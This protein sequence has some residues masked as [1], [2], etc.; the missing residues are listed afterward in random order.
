M[1]EEGGFIKMG[2]QLTWFARRYYP[3]PRIIIVGAVHIAQ[4]LTNLALMADYEVLLIDPRETWATKERF[5]GIRLI[6]SWPSEAIDQLKPDSNT[7]IVTL[8]HDPKLDDPALISALSTK[9]FYIGSLGSKRTHALRVER[10]TKIGVSIKDIERVY[11]PVGL[12]INAKTPFEI[13]VSIMAQI[14]KSN[15]ST[16]Y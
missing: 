1:H 4:P 14:I 13:A 10:L 12:N 8:S 11:G 3:N 5:P 9:S 6:Q 16:N 7:A 15:Q 2:E